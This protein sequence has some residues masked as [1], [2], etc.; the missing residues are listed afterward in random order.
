MLNTNVNTLL[1]LPQKTRLQ[2]AEKLWLSAID[3]ASLPVSDEHKNVI[4]ERMAEYH[5]GKSKPIEH[6]EVMRR[7]R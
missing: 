4:R 3:D 1:K 5:T 6:A 2:I 7:L